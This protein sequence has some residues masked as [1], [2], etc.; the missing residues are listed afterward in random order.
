M[1]VSKVCYVKVRRYKQR[2]VFPIQEITGG[3]PWN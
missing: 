1:S 2:S 3:S